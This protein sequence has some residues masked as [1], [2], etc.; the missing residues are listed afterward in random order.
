VIEEIA[1]DTLFFGRKIGRIRP[2]P[3]V[4]EIQKALARAREERFSYLTCRLNAVEI[5]AIQA[6][7]GEGFYLTDFSLVFERGLEG[8]TRPLQTARP[9]TPEDSAAIGR[10]AEGLFRTGRFY[11]DPFFTAEEARRVYRAW[12]ENSLKEAADKVFLIDGKGFV[13][14][15]ISDGRGEIPL[16][17]VS[18]GH[19]GKGTGSDLM[20]SALAW[21]KERSAASVKVRTQAVNLPA[22]AFY[23]RLGFRVSSADVTMGKILEHPG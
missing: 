17:G 13:S 23:E 8:L 16:I 15:K 7:E 10:I 11:H 6:L 18:A 12:A 14:C 22:I 3:S 9:A 4:A 21:F 19:R 20:R 1:W 5:A 2:R